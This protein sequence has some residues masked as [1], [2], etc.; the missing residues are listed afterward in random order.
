M[1]DIAELR[2]SVR[3][4]KDAYHRARE[5]D[6]EHR[7]NLKRL[8]ADRDDYA[9]RIRRMEREV[10][11]NG[12]LRAEVQRHREWRREIQQERDSSLVRIK[13]LELEVQKLKTVE[14]WRQIVAAPQVRQSA[15]KL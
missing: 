11:E 5:D 9:T 10:R 1:D 3:Y 14:A 15:F 2:R 6:F 7:H 8:Q 4:W 13:E 12:N